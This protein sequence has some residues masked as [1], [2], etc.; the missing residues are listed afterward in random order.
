[1]LEDIK[2]LLEKG[3]YEVEVF[4]P[5]LKKYLV[6]DETHDAVKTIIKYIENFDYREALIILNTMI[7]AVE[8]E[9]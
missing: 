5:K 7:S 3:N 1:M 8:E 2:P 4:I 6:F 9:T